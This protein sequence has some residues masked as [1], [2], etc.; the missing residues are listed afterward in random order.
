MSEIGKSVPKKESYDKVSGRAEYTNDQID[1]K[2][3]VV[4]LVV[5][6]YA[7]ALIKS[8]DTSRA[9]KVSGIRAI[10]TGKE[11]PILTGEG[12][13]DRAPIAIDKVR[14]HGEVVALVVADED[15]LAAKAASLIRVSYEPLPVVNSPTQAYQRNA[16]LVHE[17]LGDYEKDATTYPFP[18]TNIANHVKIRKGDLD[19]GWQDSDVVLES[20]ISFSPSDHA[21]ME[22]RVSTT[23]IKPDG[24]V[25]IHSSTQ[26]PFRVKKLISNYF[27]IPVQNIVVHT[28]LV[29]GAFGGKAPIQLEILTYLASKA[30][31]GR[32]VKLVNT[33][34]HDLIT[35]PCHIGLDAKVT[36]GATQD[37]ML[38]AAKIVFLWDGGAYADKAVDMA[39]A[40]AIDCTGP[41]FVPN[42]WCDS[43]CMYTNHTYATAFRGF[44]HTELTFAVERAMDQ[45]AKKLNLDPLE[46][47]VK[48]AI[49]PGQTTPTEALLTRSN[50]GNFQKCMQRLREMIR[51]D[52][53]GQIKQVN[54]YTVRAKGLGCFWKTS[55][56]ETNA[57]SGAVILFNQ[58]GTVNL[59]C[60]V[61]EIGTGTKTVLAQMLAERLKMDTS[62]VHVHMEVVTDLSPEHWKTVASEATH[63]A[64]RAVLKAADDA[65]DQLFEIAQ[66]VLRV[67]K[68]DLEL[69]SGHIFVKGHPTLSVPIKDIAYGYTFPN[70]NAIGGQVI[71]RGNYILKHLTTLEKETG[72]GTPGPQWT[73]GAQAVEVE[74]DLRDGSYK[75]LKAATVID[76]GKVL[77]YKGALAQVMGGMSMGLSFASSEGFIYNSQGLVLNPQLRTYRLFR[78]GEQPDYS[79]EFEETPD[80]ESAFGARGIGE[81]GVI[82]MPAALANALSLAA[83]VELTHLPLVPESIWRIRMRDSK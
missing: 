2:T 53:D 14:Y 10:L 42:V 78:Y 21:A 30:V 5:S 33:R 32:L 41:Y 26:S 79:V 63:M 76:A 81:H 15:Y 75:L 8:I 31:D 38:K 19:R 22:T 3:L 40:A 17:H 9:V 83:Q 50:I 54:A 82:G 67:E 25:I 48:N 57:P 51:W 35:S 13:K 43:F 28:P 7:H 65:I 1:R 20:T 66:F 34:E 73:V 60:G 29:G 61:V 74:L 18:G 6:T 39:N 64:G 45:L 52:Q 77:N 62:Q 36:L 47:R 56:I 44:S 58:D 37:G 80:E 68:S 4:R 72:K 69:E 27:K 12:I 23:E 46:L 71:G 59:N 49:H 55:N 24:Q 70:G 11:V 16:P